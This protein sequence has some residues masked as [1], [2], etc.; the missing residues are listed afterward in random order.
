MSDDPVCRICGAKKSE[1]RKTDIGPYTHP[2][3]ASGEGRYYL[4]SAGSIA[5]YSPGA[6]TM[7]FERWE[8]RPYKPLPITESERRATGATP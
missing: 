2:R 1:H 4:V 3:E 5:G 8:F 7:P 6:P